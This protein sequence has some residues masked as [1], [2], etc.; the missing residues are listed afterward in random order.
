[1]NGPKFKP[2]QEVVCVVDP[3]KWSNFKGYIRLLPKKNEI[4][5]VDK[6]V[7]IQWLREWHISLIEISPDDGFSQQGFEP[8]V[9]IDELKEILEQQPV[10]EHVS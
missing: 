6:I 1:M 10:E 4:Y 7:Y 5:T 2:G 3:C 8:V 9:R